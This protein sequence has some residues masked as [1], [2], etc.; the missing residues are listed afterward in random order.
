MKQ[1]ETFYV[2]QRKTGGLLFSF[3]LFQPFLFTV[4]FLP[5]ETIRVF[6]PGFLEQLVQQS[7]L[8]FGQLQLSFSLSKIRE[9]EPALLCGAQG[10]AQEPDLPISTKEFGFPSCPVVLSG[11]ALPWGEEDVLGLSLLLLQVLHH[12]HL[13]QCSNYQDF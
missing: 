11:F 10:W 6:P 2:S 1:N 12:Q 3:I 9:N 4:F 7:S 5:T 13:L 8:A